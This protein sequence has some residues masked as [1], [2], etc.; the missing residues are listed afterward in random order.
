MSNSGRTD[1]SIPG[2][3]NMLDLTPPLRKVYQ[4]VLKSADTSQRELSET[5]TDV[6]PDELRIYLNLLNRL[7]HLEKYALNGEIR[8]RIKGRIRDKSSLPDEIWKRLED[9]QKP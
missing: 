7:G 4:M 1:S 8:F 5:V 9:K 6:P 3:F 2:I